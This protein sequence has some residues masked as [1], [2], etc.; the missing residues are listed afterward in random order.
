MYERKK[1]LL[2]LNLFKDKEIID[3]TSFYNNSYISDIIP[4]FRNILTSIKSDLKI[5]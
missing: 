4:I 3:K 1:K 5:Y 2:Q